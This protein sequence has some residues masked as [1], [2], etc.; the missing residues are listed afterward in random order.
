MPAAHTD[1]PV[2]ALGRGDFSWLLKD[3]PRQIPLDVL[4]ICASVNKIS[5]RLGQT[6][7]YAVQVLP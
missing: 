7:R 3:A 1:F 5:C 4:A 6:A 2:D